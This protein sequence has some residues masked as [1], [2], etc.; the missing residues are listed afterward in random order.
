MGDSKL[1]VKVHLFLIL[2][3]DMIFNND[4]LSSID[5]DTNLFEFDEK[6]TYKNFGKYSSRIKIYS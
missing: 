5:I 2:I 4:I 6:E 1:M 3:C